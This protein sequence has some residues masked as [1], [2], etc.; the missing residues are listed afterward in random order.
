M[1]ERRAVVRRLGEGECVVPALR[2]VRRTA[3]PTGCS[4]PATGCSPGTRRGSARR[5]CRRRASRCVPS[6]SRS[7]YMDGSAFLPEPI[8]MLQLCVTVA[9]VAP[10]I[11]AGGV[12]RV[13]HHD[14]AVHVAERPRRLVRDVVARCT[15]GSSSR[16][17]HLRPGGAHARLPERVGLRR[18]CGV[19]AAGARR[20]GPRRTAR[21][22]G[23]IAPWTKYEA[24]AIHFVDASPGVLPM[25]HG[26]TGTFPAARPQ[27][28]LA[29]V[30][31]G[32][33]TCET[34]GG[35]S[36]SGPLSVFA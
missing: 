27:I 10:G 17:P 16:T 23:K 13:D 12:V 14:L 33:D 2:L 26:M 22:H 18:A 20:Q 19:R 6:H 29:S 8:M 1:L 21:C 7:S 28:S 31:A 24:A 34:A 9:S 15:S 35:G 4:T 3:R 11:P 30:S 5:P 32:R 25:S 36:A